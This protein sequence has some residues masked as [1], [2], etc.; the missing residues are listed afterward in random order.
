MV[1]SSHELKLEVTVNGSGF[2]LPSGG[3]ITKTKEIP[4]A[5]LKYPNK[6]G[7]MFRYFTGRDI[8]RIYVGIDELPTEPN[9]V[10]YVASMSGTVR[11]ELQ[12]ISR[13]HSLEKEYIFIDEFDNYDGWEV[14]RAI[15]KQLEDC[16][17]DLTPTSDLKGTDPLTFIP[18]T[19]RQPTGITR[20]QLVKYARDL[21]Y[22]YDEST[23]K[24]Y[25]YMLYE[26]G[27]QN[28]VFEK[29]KEMKDGDEWN[30]FIYGDNLI[31]SVPSIKQLGVVNRQVVIDKD[32]NRIDF[33]LTQDQQ[34]SINGIME[35]APIENKEANSN[36]AYMQA[37][38]ECLSKRNPVV[39]TSIKDIRLIDTV[40]YLSFVKISGAPNLLDG[41][42][43]VVQTQINFSGGLKVGCNLERQIPLY[44]DELVSIL[45]AR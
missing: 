25:N 4:T 5:Q 38:R 39:N 10:G 31:A 45:T 34:L 44:G 36:E 23:G 6:D 20:Y 16:D 40:P 3:S 29:Q 11:S 27:D 7:K 19:Y 12:L 17:I 43:R 33:N 18:S 35:G 28:F 42:H 8:V 32:G 13:L 1:G 24:L 41:H 9:F 37:R 14:A 22:S 2:D 21:A 26:H 30:T 15:Q